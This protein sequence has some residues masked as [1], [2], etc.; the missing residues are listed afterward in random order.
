VDGI[1]HL[2]AIF[3]PYVVVFVSE[4]YGW[5]RFFFL[6]AGAALLAGV[7]LLPIWN[8]KPSIHIGAKLE[9]EA[10]PQEARAASK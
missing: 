10:M 6:L 3:S 2:G 9:N 7:V 5:D 1:G 4:R 8:L